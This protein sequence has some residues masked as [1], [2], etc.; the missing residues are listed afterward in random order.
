M[1]FH[2]DIDPE[3]I[4]LNETK[5]NPKT[6]RARLLK[7]LDGK[8]YLFCLTGINNDGSC[9]KFNKVSC[10]IKDYVTLDNSNIRLYYRTMKTPEGKILEDLKRNFPKVKFKSNIRAISLIKNKKVEVVN[11][12]SI[13]IIPVY[14]KIE[15]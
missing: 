7:Y 14:D 15:E 9:I 13:D 2:I 1:K 3:N 8:K 4:K 5:V 12:I 11:I 10:E 6:I